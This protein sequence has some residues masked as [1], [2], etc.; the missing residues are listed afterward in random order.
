MP[1]RARTRGRELSF[2]RML[3][4]AILL[5][6]RGPALA[7]ALGMSRYAHTAWRVRDGFVKDA[8][9]AIAQTRDG[10]LWLGTSS[11]FYRFDG[12]RAVPWDKVGAGQLPSEQ[13]RSLLVG[14]D[15][16]LWIATLKGLAS[17]KDGK[18][19]QY[20]E[21]SGQ[22][23]S[24]LLQDRDGT[25]WLG[26]YA[27]GRVC[28]VL[29][30]R[31]TCYGSGSFGTGVH[32][33]YEDR[34]GA[35][36]LC[37]QTGLW[38]WRPGAPERYSLPG[39]GHVEISAINENTDGTLW[40]ATSDG[41]KQLTNG[42]I[43]RLP[44]PG[45]RSRVR[46][47]RV[48]ET[49]DRNLWIGSS[50]G[51]LQLHHGSLDHLGEVDGLSGDVVEA[52]FQDREG[53]VWV[54]TTD[55]LDRFRELAVPTLGPREGLSSS[56]ATA[57][58][59]APDGSIWIASTESLNRWTDGHVTDYG[60]GE[61]LNQ[62]SAPAV[63]TKN[64]STATEHL[65]KKGFEGPPRSLGLDDDGRLLASGPNGI[66]SLANG[67]FRRV[68]GVPGG[69]VRSL[70]GDGHRGIW[71]LGVESGLLD[72]AHDGTIERLDGKHRNLQFSGTA[73][74]PDPFRG[75]VWVGY[76]GGGIAF[77]KDAKLR[78][79]YS[80]AVGLGDGSVN[81]LWLGGDSI[82]WAATD[83][84]LSRLEGNHFRTLTT[85]DGLPCTP[86]T[87]AVED[88]DHSFW[89]NQPCALVRISR[90]EMV[91]WVADPRHSLRVSLFD[92][93]DGVRSGYSGRYGP[94]VTRSPDGRIWFLSG[95][96]VSIIDP[97]HLAFNALPPPVHVEEITADGKTYRPTAGLRLPPAIRNLSID[98]TALSLAVPEKVHFRFMLEGQDKDWREVVN[99]RRVEYSNLPPKQYRFRLTASN[100]SGVWNT[101]GTTLEFSIA[102]AFYQT[103]W[104]RALVA[105][106]FCGMLAGLYRL[107]IRQLHLQEERFRET[108][109]SMPAMAFVTAPNG[110]RQF[111]NR[112]WTD[113]SG[114]PLEQARGFGWLTIVHPDD[115]ER[116]RARWRVALSS[117]VP[118]EYEVRLRGSDGQYRCFFTR[119]VAQRNKAGHV[120]RW[121]GVATDI[122]ERKNAELER[123]RFRQ[124][125]ADLAHVHRVTTMGEL[126][127]SLAHEIR[128]P[129][130]AT[131]MNA[132]AAL[133]W[134]ER[135]Q[136]DLAEARDAA[137]RIVSDSTRAGEIISRLR[138]L[139]K[140]APPQRELVD[141]NEVIREMLV[142]L[143][144]EATRYGV[145]LRTELTDN[146]PRITGDRVQLQQVFMNLML[147][148]IE[149]MRD[150]GGLLTVTSSLDGERAVE[151]VVSDLGV[152]LPAG[153]VDQIF[154]PFFTTKTHG[155]GMGLSISRSIVDSHGG[156]LWATPN[157]SRGATFHFTLPTAAEPASGSE[158]DTPVPDISGPADRR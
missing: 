26:A 34:N 72:V 35:L 2:V 14:R 97:R 75:G 130:A 37:A 10:Y 158:S 15:G 146:L 42:R 13:I 51:L 65:T 139:Y 132:N 36:W 50:Q 58:Q 85:R 102:P 145:V 157:M 39:G 144:G 109:E 118:V 126:T 86:V 47:L 150:R 59:A 115:R 20:P 17:W 155:S 113:Y 143:T 48:F 66:F 30:G 114:L 107:R 98:Y 103:N 29:R 38:R 69:N 64:L 3:S 82:L 52:I 154:T 93:Y 136:P 79:S 89:L 31:I 147:N 8:I 78:A 45:L 60:G 90:S 12:V 152:G 99:Q 133:R 68:T 11:G 84:G 151:V 100:N 101:E 149:A 140:K 96:G 116:V 117:G 134:L 76:Y 44:L 80:A 135:D 54:G 124:L 131:M 120:T 105:L 1:K 71:V 148:G 125:E 25:V 41:L 91:A 108:V 119:A 81:D 9:N 18:L 23:I 32:C 61:P 110:A 40:L 7:Q 5:W 142:L 24:G 57:V 104:F 63:R 55:G 16:T 19:T 56:L 156:R 27:P 33:L 128:Q 21:L 92:S 111:V 123:E 121:Y 129:I 106:A 141:V 95:D 153:K 94:R 22:T 88:A 4:I 137:R 77:F 74:L 28:A 70:A 67:R 112:R 62:R 127:A 122:E 87:W 6:P 46:P 73:S 138:S 83:G 53:T 49:S 43:E